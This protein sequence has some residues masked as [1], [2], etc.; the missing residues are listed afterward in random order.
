MYYR[1]QK[2]RRL[3]RK[4][5]ASRGSEIQAVVAGFMGSTAALLCSDTVTNTTGWVGG[6]QQVFVAHS[7]GSWKSKSRVLARSGSGEDPLPGCRLVAV[8]SG[9]GGRGDRSLWC[10]FSKALTPFTWVEPSQSPHLLI[11]SSWG[12]GIST[13]ES[14][15]DTFSPQQQAKWNEIHLRNL[16]SPA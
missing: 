13:Y 4:S 14:W 10:L 11:Q 15:G 2:E 8:S 3:E 6:R 1:S 16:L 9:R 12:V 7:A 5:A